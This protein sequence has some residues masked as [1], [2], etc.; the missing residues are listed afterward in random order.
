M[1]SHYCNLLTTTKGAVSTITNPSWNVVNS[2]PNILRNLIK[3]KEKLHQPSLTNPIKQFE[4]IRKFSLVIQ[5][6]LLPKKLYRFRKLR[7]L[8]RFTV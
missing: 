1:H 4:S 7:N 3:G 5:L 2:N 8:S 6:L